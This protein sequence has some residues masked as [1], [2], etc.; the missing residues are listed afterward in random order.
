M[1]T[2]ELRAENFE[3]TT[4]ENDI[5]LIDFWT[6]WGGLCRQF[7]PVYQPASQTHPD[8]VFD[9]VDIEAGQPPAAAAQITSPTSTALKHGPQAVTKPGTLPADAKQRLNAAF[10]A[11]KEN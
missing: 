1:A 7:A 11:M 10:T 6:S 4:T 3:R 8:V 9:K 2:I 5:V